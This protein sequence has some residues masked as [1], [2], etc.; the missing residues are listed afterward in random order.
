MATTPELV[1]VLLW[2]MGIGFVFGWLIKEVAAGYFGKKENR[3]PISDREI[4]KAIRGG[5]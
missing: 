1:A 3:K 2:G 4:I 5:K